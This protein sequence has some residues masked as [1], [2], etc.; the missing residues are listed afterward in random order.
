MKPR[1]LALFALVSLIS[2]SA[3]AS[4]AVSLTNP[5]PGQGFGKVRIN[6]AA[7]QTFTFSNTGSTAQ[8]LG[9]AAIDANLASCAALGCPSVSVADFVL[10]AGK[11][12]C[13][14]KT[15]A[16]AQ[17]CTLQA[18]FAPLS[19]GPK[20]ARLV[21]T[22][23]QGGAAETMLS[24]TGLYQ[25]ADCLFDW[26]EKTFPQRYPAPSSSF[27]AGAYYA[28]CYNSQASC[29]GVD[30]VYPSFAAA[31]GYISEGGNIQSVGTLQDL[32]KTAGCE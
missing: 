11:D 9:T 27:Y 24:G 14:G 28:R 31:R 21:M 25:P 20:I 19:G 2:F 26:A 8:T 6:S 18:E 12:E 17:S 10:S 32:A 3:P 23:A 15:L 5:A 1:N 16:P 13:S 29:I 4:A 22:I 30:G 7:A